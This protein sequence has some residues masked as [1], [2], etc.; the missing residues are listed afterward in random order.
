MSAL[1]L[2][3]PANCRLCPR[4][5]EFR[6]ANRLAIAP[7]KTPRAVE[8][9]LMKVVPPRFLSHAHHWLILHGRYICKARKPL[10]GSCVLL[11]LCP[12]EPKTVAG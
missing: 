8:D 6:V 10:C 12:F 11:D 1:P 5:A 4:L 3:P 7:G 2:Q 9:E